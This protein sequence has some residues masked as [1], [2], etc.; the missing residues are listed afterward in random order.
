MNGYRGR[1]A[2]FEIMIVTDAIRELIMDRKP[3]SAIRVAARQ[4]GMRTLRES[5]LL[6]IYEGITTVEEVLRETMQIM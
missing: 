4:E 2:I 6:R 3:T 5:G 1:I